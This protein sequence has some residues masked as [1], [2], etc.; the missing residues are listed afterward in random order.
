MRADPERKRTSTNPNDRSELLNWLSPLDYSSLHEA[1]SSR[2]QEGAG[3]WLLD[4]QEY[5]EWEGGDIQKLWCVG[6]RK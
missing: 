2:A 4:S 1:Y 3:Q 5:L 6:K